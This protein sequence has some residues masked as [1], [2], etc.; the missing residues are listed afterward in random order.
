MKTLF[1]IFLFVLMLNG[2]IATGFSPSSLVFELGQNQEEC[3]MITVDSI[4]ET[5]NISD[6]WAENKGIE[7]K[8]NLFEKDANYHGISINYPKE[9]S[10]NEKQAEVCLSGSNVGE[11]HGVILLRE[12]QQGNSIVQ[13]GVWI[14]AT[15]AETQSS[16]E[17]ASAGGG[18]GGG[19]SGSIVSSNK[20]VNGTTDEKN[21]KVVSEMRKETTDETEEKAGN[22]WN[23][24]TGFIIG[25]N[26]SQRNWRIAG[27]CL[28]AICVA[29][30]IF[31]NKRRKKI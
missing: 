19:S 1:F 13:M 15:I 5:I 12:E 20:T 18:S 11:Y 25:E 17:T 21:T 4:S 27:L 31:I 23:G 26:N 8:V 6:K 10:Q 30:F 9:L 7:W 14:K 16:Q 2:V 29:G 22:S 28:A 24:I 3:K